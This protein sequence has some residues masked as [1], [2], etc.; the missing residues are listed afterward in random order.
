MNLPKL[1]IYKFI[2]RLKVVDS[3]NV[4][5]YK[6]AMIRG[7]FG[8]AFKKVTCITRM[9]ECE[10][11]MLKD[12][13]SYFKIF[14]TEKPDNNIF[15]LRGVKKIP[16]PFVLQ[17]PPDSRRVY[18]QNEDMDVGVTLFGTG[19]NYFPYFVYTFIKMGEFGLGKG[20]GHFEL[21]DVFS[22]GQSGRKTRIY[23]S[24]SGKIKSGYKPLNLEKLIS[25]FPASP[26]KTTLEF[27]TPFRYQSENKV[28]WNPELLDINRVLRN[29]EKRIF[30][31]AVLY[32]D[33]QIKDPGKT[34][35]P[36][37]KIVEN[38]LTYKDWERY[39]TRQKKRF[40]LGGFTGKLTLGGDLSSVM[41]MLILGSVV[42]IG[43]NTLFGLGAY[44]LKAE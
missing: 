28:V 15:Y 16:H 37:I 44:T 11:C 30:S 3:L 32:G 18:R 36:D 34:E 19:I 5:E 22:V 20:R 9:K 7:A 27:H 12:T 8:Y 35:Y 38:S 2:F 40:S 23:D 31:L 13:C 4:P 1:E 42:S 6:G 29:I 41:P 39:S 14:E 21:K 24:K 43:K 25:G 26:Q 10:P 33:S 17:P